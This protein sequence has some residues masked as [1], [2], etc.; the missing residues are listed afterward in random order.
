VL[1]IDNG[2]DSVGSQKRHSENATDIGRINLFRRR[3]FLDG[4]VD[5]RL[6]QRAL[7]EGAGKCFDH[8]VV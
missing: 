4:P 1:S 5:P 3:Q 6:Q 8:G 2:F 7:P